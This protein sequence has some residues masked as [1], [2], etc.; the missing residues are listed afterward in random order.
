[1]MKKL[2]IFV[3]LL[4]MI[5]HPVAL[6]ETAIQSKGQYE[7]DKKEGIWEYFDIDGNLQSKGSFE[8]DRRNGIWEV[9]YKNGA[10]EQKGTFLND[11]QNGIWEY[12]FPEG[13]LKIKGEWTAGNRQGYWEYYNDETKEI[14]AKRFKEDIEF[15]GYKFGQ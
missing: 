10:L 2:I 5:N 12:F 3:P 6:S 9:Y 11:K 7:N 1:M 8:N 15:F 4:L 13:T 14:V